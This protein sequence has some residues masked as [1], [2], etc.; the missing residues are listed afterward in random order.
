MP[1]WLRTEVDEYLDTRP[2]LPP[3]EEVASAASYL[4]NAGVPVSG[5]SLGTLLGLKRDVARRAYVEWKTGEKEIPLPVSAHGLGG[6]LSAPSSF[7]QEK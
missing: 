2:Y 6:G 4:Q 5:P 3:A 1:Y 7:R